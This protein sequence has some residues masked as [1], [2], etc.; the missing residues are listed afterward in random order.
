ML[1]E[2]TAGDTAA[3]VAGWVALIIVFAGMNDDG[4]T[5]G[6]EHRIRLDLLKRDR[7]VHH[8]DRQLAAGWNMQIGMSPAWWP[9]AAIMPCFLL[10]GLK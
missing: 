7:S 5:V 9:S 2:N 1:L 4:R 6:I 8:L 3:R 10:P